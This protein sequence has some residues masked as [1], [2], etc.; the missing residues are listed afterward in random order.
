[1]CLIC[2]DNRH[3]P[4]VITHIRH[5]IYTVRR[6]CFIAGANPPVYSSDI[7]GKALR[8][9][10]DEIFRRIPRIYRLPK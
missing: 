4:V 6:F 2:K 1:V 5:K 8:I 10:N 7:L 3:I 9:K